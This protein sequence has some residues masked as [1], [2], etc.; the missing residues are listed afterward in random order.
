[1]HY[2][3]LPVVR[4]HLLSVHDLDFFFFL[5]DSRILINDLKDTACEYIVR[6]WLPVSRVSV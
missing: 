5:K 1:M 3:V 2:L 4:M 6:N